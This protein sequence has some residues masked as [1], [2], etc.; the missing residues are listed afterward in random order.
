MR[1][2]WPWPGERWESVSDGGMSTV[3][4]HL[5]WGTGSWSKASPA[6]DAGAKDGAMWLS[7]RG[8]FAPGTPRANIHAMIQAAEDWS[9]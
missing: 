3:K 8:G 9:G 5:L 2:G 6:A 4:E 1:R 7:V